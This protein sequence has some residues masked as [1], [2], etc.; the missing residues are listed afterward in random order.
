FNA[1]LPWDMTFHSS[2][3]GELFDGGGGFVL[4][5]LAGAWAVS[6]LHRDLRPLALAALAAL[7]IPLV[8]LQYLRYAYPA[9]VLLVPIALVAWARV[10]P[11]RLA[12]L[13]V[14]LCLLNLAFQSSSH[15]MLR[16][17]AVKQTVLA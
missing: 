6:L 14:G 10:A 15:W 1:L 8:P 3:Y 16:T 11:Y 9:M 2:R 7:V 5:A 17:G 12:W 13:G 4:V